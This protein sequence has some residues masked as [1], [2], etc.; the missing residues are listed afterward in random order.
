MPI[1]IGGGRIP[2]L[3]SEKNPSRSFQHT[4]NRETQPER[5]RIALI[6]NMPDAALEDTEL[7]FYELLDAASGD[8]PISLKLYSLPDLPRGDAGQR[9]LNNYYFDMDDLLNGRF[10]GMIMTG[11]EPRQPD[12]RNEPYWPILTKVLDWAEKNTASTVLSCLAAHAGV[13]HSDGIP[14]HKLRDKQFGVFQYKRVREHALTAGTGE[15]MKIPHSRWN[16]VRADALNSCGYE[17]LVQSAQAGVDLFV[18]K[19]RDSLFVHFQ[20]HPEYGTRTLL[21]E[22]RRDVKRFL[23]R[24]RETYPTMPHEYFDDAAINLLSD[25]RNRVVANPRE[26]L[27]EEFPEASV[28]GSL[29]GTWQASAASLYRNWLHYLISR[30]TDASRLSAMTPAVRHG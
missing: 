6:N 15:I 28:A 20:G 22:Y 3:L 11:T 24:E 1:V 4:D 12:L 14:R 23:K 18:K 25:F 19:K 13:L 8:I 30:K 7:Q 2:K 27:L 26:Q 16:E 21:K 29:R 10:D 9:H 5:L 17:I